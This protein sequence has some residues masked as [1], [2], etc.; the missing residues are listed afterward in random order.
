MGE[1]PTNNREKTPE[2]LSRW[3]RDWNVL[4][5][6]ALGGLALTIP[7]PNIVLGSLAGINAAQAGGFELLRSR[8]NRAHYQK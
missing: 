1:K 7:G 5:A 2:R 6:V 3:A 4:G 8:A